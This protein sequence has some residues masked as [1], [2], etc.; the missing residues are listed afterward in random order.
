MLS[1]SN[2]ANV[3]LRGRVI[4]ETMKTLVIRGKGTHRIAKKDAIFKF[5]LDGV[6]VKVEGKALM[7]RPED[8]VK[9]QIKKK[10]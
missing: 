5:N 3:L 1:D 10:W 7:G 6:T 2:P 8:Q 9:K 4:D